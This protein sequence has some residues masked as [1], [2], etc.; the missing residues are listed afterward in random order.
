MVVAEP[1]C[2]FFGD[3]GGDEDSDER[4]VRV[5]TSSFFLPPRVE[6]S[7]LELASNFV[8]ATVFFV[9]RGSFAFERAFRGGDFSCFCGLIPWVVVGVLRLVPFASIVASVVGGG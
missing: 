2:F 7:A 1:L 5:D 8:F 6:D 4:L 3:P 9:L